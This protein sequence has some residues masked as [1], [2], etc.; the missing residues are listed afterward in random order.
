MSVWLVRDYDITIDA[1][2]IAVFDNDT[3]KCIAG[4]V[5]IPRRGVA[6][7]RPWNRNGDGM[8]PAELIEALRDLADELEQAT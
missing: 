4:P 7:R 5:N 6:P 3:G 1:E 2:Q 8:M